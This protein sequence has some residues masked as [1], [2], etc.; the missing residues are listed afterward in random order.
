MAQE[1]LSLPMGPRL[2]PE[3]AGE[4]ISEVASFPA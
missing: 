2:S 4:V 1:V 3:Q